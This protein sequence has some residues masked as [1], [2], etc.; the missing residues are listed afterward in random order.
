MIHFYFIL[1]YCY[2]T[3]VKGVK[4][5]SFN[6]MYFILSK[7][8]QSRSKILWEIQCYHKNCRNHK[9]TC[10][11]LQFNQEHQNSSKIYLFSEKLTID[12]S[13]NYYLVF[14]N[15]R[16]INQATYNTMSNF[17]KITKFTPTLNSSNGQI[18][19]PMQFFV[20]IA[21]LLSGG[22]YQSTIM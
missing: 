12:I 9:K 19:I 2:W 18:L 10:L 14:F 15:R 3:F 11:F 6:I 5:F 8:A 13:S 20:Q 17:R 16:R 4:W 21:K 22:T 1:L 7:Y